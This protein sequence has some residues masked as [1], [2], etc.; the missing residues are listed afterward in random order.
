MTTPTTR[1]ILLTTAQSLI[2]GYNARTVSAAL[3]FRAPH[4]IHDIYP[5]SLDRPPMD[6]A[7]YANFIEHGMSI[8]EDTKLMIQHHRTI[9]DVEK[10]E[11]VLRVCDISERNDVGL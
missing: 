6:N 3:S 9:V 2:D 11:V 1:Q 5:L 8:Y 10:R 4:C 7:A